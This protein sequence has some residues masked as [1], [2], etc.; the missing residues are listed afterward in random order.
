[1]LANQTISHEWPSSSLGEVSVVAGRQTA[2]RHL[3]DG[4]PD[5]AAHNADPAATRLF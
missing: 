3:V 5:F 2:N 1:V 4:H